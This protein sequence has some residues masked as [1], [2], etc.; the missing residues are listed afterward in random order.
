[1]LKV[2]VTAVGNAMGI[3]L[4]QEVLSKLNVGKDDA[5]YLV[6]NA[7]GFVLTL[8]QQAFESQMD[9]AEKV[10]KKYHDAFQALA[11]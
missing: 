11:K 6:E 1:M 5:L 8:Q 3:V 4:P 7:E 9:A 10:L 2:K